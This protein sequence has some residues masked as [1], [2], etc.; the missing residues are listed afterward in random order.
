[1]S[2]LIVVSLISTTSAILISIIGVFVSHKLLKSE[3]LGKYRTELIAKQISAC[4]SLWVNL[5]FASKSKVKGALIQKHKDG[6]SLNGKKVFDLHKGITDIVNSQHGLYF[7]K[8][9]RK[10]VYE[11]RNF[12]E[13]E[14]GLDAKHIN[15]QV[16]NTKANKLDG[17]VQNLRVAIRK[18]LKLEDIKAAKEGPL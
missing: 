2:D 15:F 13:D 17:Y 1:M 7:S 16:S 4:E 5:S 9:L 18:E 10:S 3:L 8:E 6:V 14:I 11:L 12:I